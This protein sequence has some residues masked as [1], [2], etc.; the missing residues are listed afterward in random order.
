V[1]DEGP[2]IPLPDEITISRDEA[3]ILLAALDLGEA[4]V[5]AEQ[6]PTIQRAIRIVTGSCG[7]HSAT[8]STAPTTNLDDDVE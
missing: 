3:G 5:D 4:A 1:S 7:Q 6:R 2:R 8:F